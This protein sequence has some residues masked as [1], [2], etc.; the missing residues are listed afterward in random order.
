MIRRPPRSTQGVSS[1]ASDVYKRQA[2]V[3]IMT[4]RLWTLLQL[5]HRQRQSQHPHHHTRHHALASA[6][7]HH[8]S[9]RQLGMCSTSTR[10][11]Q[12][13][14]CTLLALGRRASVVSTTPGGTAPRMMRSGC[15][16]PR[17]QENTSRSSMLPNSCARDLGANSGMS[18]R[19]STSSEC[20]AV[21]ANAMR[22]SGMMGYVMQWHHGLCD[23]VT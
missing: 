10:M 20:V 8:M 9:I 17:F 19:A 4:S 2:L 15:G 22:C 6:L 23:A 13:E 1:A 3:K 12:R 7:T 11:A 18:A 21:R 5:R 14:S 16:M